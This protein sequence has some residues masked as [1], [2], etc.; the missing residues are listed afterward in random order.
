MTTIIMLF[1]LPLGLLLYFYDKKT[2]KQNLETFDDYVEKIKNSDLGDEDKILKINDMYYNNGY[3]N[4]HKTDKELI[5]EKKHF[6]PG[7]LLM[8]FGAL[9]YFG[10][11]F[12]YIYYKF[13][14]KP[15]QIKVTLEDQG[16]LS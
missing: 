11:I 1:I 3:I 2:H 15:E 16:E 12:Y 7:V 14:L 9:T 6:N 10:L 13:F 8:Y 4:T 5:V